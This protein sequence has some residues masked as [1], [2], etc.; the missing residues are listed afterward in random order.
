MRG[1]PKH[2]IYLGMCGVAGLAI[3]GPI[4]MAE[5]S[6]D[7]EYVGKRVLTNGPANYCPAEDNVSVTIH[8][9]TLTFTNSAVQNYV[10]PFDP[11]R[12]GT[13]DETHINV[14]G[15]IVGIQGRIA[16]RALDAEVNNPPCLH[17]WW[18]DKK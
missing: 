14:G 3:A 8:G 7:G 1:I 16:G 6:Y 9:R 12:D 10:I 2:R 18:L 4:A 11:K 5:G 17:H 13:F 15:E